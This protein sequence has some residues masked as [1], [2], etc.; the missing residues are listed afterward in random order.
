MSRALDVWIA[1]AAATVP[2]ISIR[3]IHVIAVFFC[4]G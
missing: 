4:Q 3:D 1:V 2:E